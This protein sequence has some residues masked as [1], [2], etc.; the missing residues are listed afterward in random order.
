MTIQPISHT[1]ARVRPVSRSGQSFADC[2]KDARGKVCAKCH[3]SV[4]V[5]YQKGWC[6]ECLTPSLVAGKEVIDRYR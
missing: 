1:T 6:K 4:I 2:L 5:T 3:R